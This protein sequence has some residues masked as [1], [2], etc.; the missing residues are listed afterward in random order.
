MRLVPIYIFL[1]SNVLCIWIAL[2]FV[3]SLQ[4]LKGA[5]MKHTGSMTLMYISR[6]HFKQSKISMLILHIYLLGCFVNVLVIF[7]YIWEKKSYSQRI[8]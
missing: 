2:H 7:G 8:S 5:Y 1:F 6:S 3:F 4:A